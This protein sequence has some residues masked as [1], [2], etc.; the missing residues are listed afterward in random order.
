MLNEEKCWQLLQDVKA[1]C[2]SCKFEKGS[3]TKCD[4][5]SCLVYGLRCFPL[6]QEAVQERIVAD[7]QKRLAKK[8]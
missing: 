1:T 2:S 8:A 3:R 6:Q 7:L 5:Q 4:Q